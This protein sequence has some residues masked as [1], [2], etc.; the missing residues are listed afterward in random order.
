M[1]VITA[2]LEKIFPSISFNDD[3]VDRIDL[4]KQ[5]LIMVGAY[6]LIFALFIHGYQYYLATTWRYLGY[7]W[8]P[9]LGRFI[10]SLTAILIIATFLPKKFKKPSD[11][12]LHIHFLFPVLPM[13][14]INAAME[15]PKPFT[16][17][18]VALFL[19]IVIVNK[20][21]LFRPLGHF[22]LSGDLLQQFTFAW[23]VG[24]VMLFIAVGGLSHINFDLALIYDTRGDASSWKPGFFNYLTPMTTKVILPFALI[25]S[26][27]KRRWLCLFGI[28][29][30]SVLLF[31]FTNHK[32]VFFHPYA[33][34]FLFFLL[35]RKRVI[36]KLL[37]CF[38]GLLLFIQ[39]LHLALGEIAELLVSMF[40]RRVFFIPALINY[41]FHEFFTQNA[42]TFWA[43]NTFTLGMVKKLYTLNG[44]HTIGYYYFKNPETSANTGWIGSGY[45]QAGYWGMVIYA[46]IIALIF[47][48]ADTLAINRKKE[49]VTAG[50]VIPFLAMFSASDLPTSLLTHGL[51]V[52][53][54]FV[55]L[56]PRNSEL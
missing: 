49:I 4:F 56:L 16:F 52:A 10:E 32:A 40:L 31:G 55:T 37:M 47:N 39:G 36:N 46:V 7:Y 27:V 20:F 11:I 43:N 28:L 41:H 35:H 54:M 21:R 14:V 34:L 48:F 29:F 23:V 2:V 53:L 42:H 17:L 3:I 22:S 50:I 13:L 33:V 6:L 8:H 45:M 5:W 26:V 44:A 1:S 38:T 25:L 19:M 30:C 24:V 15:V 9:D 18:A 12:L 51:L